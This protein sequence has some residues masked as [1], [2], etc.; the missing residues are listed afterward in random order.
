MYRGNAAYGKYLIAVQSVDLAKTKLNRTEQSSVE[1]MKVVERRLQGQATMYGKTLPGQMA[2]FRAKLDDLEIKFGNWLLPKALSVVSWVQKDVLPAF[3]SPALRVAAAALVGI[4]IIAA[5]GKFA[6]NH[7]I[8][9]IATLSTRVFGFF[10][11]LAKGGGIKNAITR[12]FT[13]QSSSLEASAQA[14]DGSATNLTAAAEKLA[15]GGAGGA[16]GGLEGTAVGAEGALLAGGRGI[17]GAGETGAMGLLG[18]VLGPLGIAYGAHTILQPWS[19]KSLQMSNAGQWGLSNMLDPLG[20][21]N[22]LG[23]MWNE[24]MWA[25]NGVKGLFGN[26][27]GKHGSS[28]MV[29][30]GKFKTALERDGQAI[31][32]L[33]RHGMKMKNIGQLGHL[34]GLAE[35][36]KWTELHKYF[37]KMDQSKLQQYVQH[38]TAAINGLSSIL[39]KHGNTYVTIKNTDPNTKAIASHTSKSASQDVVN[40]KLLGKIVTQLEQLNKSLGTTSGTTHHLRSPALAAGH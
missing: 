9:P 31:A 3:K 17:L 20:K 23:M 37:S 14:L 30:W 39:G 1:I 22:P 33:E 13:G 29:S 40:G 28:S 25:L 27:G 10:S 11:E 38:N 24:S 18:D 34:I 26:G 15:A 4:P 19:S 21:L 5:I 12:L 16:V 6:A 7:I 2:V 8:H 32:S 36:G 35:A